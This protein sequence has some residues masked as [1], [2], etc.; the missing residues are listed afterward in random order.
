MATDQ[1]RSS[2]DS[3]ELAALNRFCR[4]VTASAAHQ[5][6]LMACSSPEDILSMAA[7][8]DCLFSRQTLRSRSIDLAA[9]CW[10]WAQKGTTWRRQFF[11]A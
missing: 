11:Q 6:R 4:A 2:G 5:A 10:P 3:A 7:E 8:L 9:D 1:E